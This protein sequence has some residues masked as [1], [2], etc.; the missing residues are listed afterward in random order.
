[1]NPISFLTRQMFYNPVQPPAGT[2]TAALSPAKTQEV[3]EAKESSADG[4]K[5][6]RQPD[7]DT[8]ECQTCKNRKYKDGSDDPG[9]SF[10]TATHLDPE[11]APYAIRSHEGEHVAHNKAKA[12]KENREIVS[13]TVTYHTDICPEC[14][15]VYMSGGTTRTV[16]KATG[17]KN[18][19]EGQMDRKGVYLD[20]IA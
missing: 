18:P 5:V 4:Q 8:Y 7:Y 14:G 2:Q 16:S 9:V 10:K 3:G 19:F 1:M 17:E 6:S 20:L 13:Q 11:A 15:R 12:Q